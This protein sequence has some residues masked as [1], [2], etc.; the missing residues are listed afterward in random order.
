MQQNVL[1]YLNISKYIALFFH[2]PAFSPPPHCFPQNLQ[3]KCFLAILFCKILYYLENTKSAYVDRDIIPSIICIIVSIICQNFMI[4]LQI[5]CGHSCKLNSTKA[6]QCFKAIIN[7]NFKGI[8]LK[9]Y[10]SINHHK[11]YTSYLRYIFS[12]NIDRF[13]A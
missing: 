12:R 13:S 5:K 7:V 8:E 1:F 6:Q 9:S 4:W 2:F 3:N 11:S 10:F